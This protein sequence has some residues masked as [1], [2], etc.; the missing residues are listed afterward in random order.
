MR[1]ERKCFWSALTP[2]LSP[3]E[4]E[5]GGAASRRGP[6]GL[7]QT[8]A[9]PILRA[10]TTTLTEERH[11]VLPKKLC[12]QKKLR[13]GDHFE[14]VPDEDDPNVILLRR[15]APGAKDDL[16]EVLLA[17]PVKGFLPRIKRRKEPM[18]KVRL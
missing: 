3:K 10:M 5:N 9:G 6:G 14:V 2:A 8:D 4:R 11:I 16:L 7:T 17:C 15:L 1:V 18:R 13:A 12:A